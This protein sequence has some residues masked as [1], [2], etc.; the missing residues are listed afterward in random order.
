M[1]R[2][3]AAV[4]WNYVMEVKWE[5]L[6]GSKID[7]EGSRDDDG[8]RQFLILSLFVCFSYFSDSTGAQPSPP[9]TSSTRNISF[10]FSLTNVLISGYLAVIAAPKDDGKI[11]KQKTTRK[12]P[13]ADKKKAKEKREKAAGG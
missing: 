10:H 11:N 7:T 1:C 3:S 5:S 4:V 9:P 12:E 2:R 13:S 8:P 6:G